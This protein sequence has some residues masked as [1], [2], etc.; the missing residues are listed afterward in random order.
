MHFQFS[1][2]FVYYYY[3]FVIFPVQQFSS[4]NLY[5]FA[6][7]MENNLHISHIWV[8]LDWILEFSILKCHF[9]MYHEQI[10]FCS[11]FF[12]DIFVFTCLSIYQWNWLMAA[13][14][15]KIIISYKKWKIEK[16]DKQTKNRMSCWENWKCEQKKKWMW[17]QQALDL[18]SCCICICMHIPYSISILIVWVKFLVAKSF[19]CDSF[20]LICCY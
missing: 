1:L 12:F 7:C 10:Q 3:L 14:D 5:N 15:F 9:K 16:K 18:H 8:L 13:T 2:S 17:Q 19:P 20:A 4:F 11:L 6:D